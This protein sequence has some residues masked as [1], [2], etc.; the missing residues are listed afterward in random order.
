MKNIII[1]ICILISNFCFS[2]NKRQID[3][4][5]KLVQ[6]SNDTTK[7][8]CYN[9]LGKLYQ[10]NNNEKVKEYGLKIIELASK[11]KNQKY[12]AAGYLKIGVYFHLENKFDSALYYYNKTILLSKAYN[13]LII[14]ADAHQDLGILYSNMANDQKAID[15]LIIAQKIQHQLKNI[16]K[17]ADLLNNIAVIFIRQKN[18]N[19]AEKYILESI[20]L[21]D[22]TIQKGLLGYQYTNL[23]IIYE[24]RSQ[25]QKAINYQRKALLEFSQINDSRGMA[26]CY[27]NLF[28]SF[29]NQNKIDSALIFN[30]KL[31]IISKKQNDIGNEFFSNLNFA[32]VYQRFLNKPVYA[33]CY[34]DSMREF[35]PKLNKPEFYTVFYQESATYNLLYGNKD[36]GYFYMDK[37]LGLKDS[38]TSSENAQITNELQTKYETEKKDLE[39]K[40][41]NTEL[42]FQEEKNKQKTVVLWI[43]STALFCTLF[44][45]I[46]AFRNYKKAKKAN[47]II[48]DQNKI[49]ER[50]K[51]EVEIQKNIIEEKQSE[52]ISS[53]NYAQRIQS[54]VLTG[55]EVWNKI[56]KEHF[57]VFQPRDIVSGDFYWAH[58]LPNGRAVFALADCTGHGVPGGF[59]S[60]L[61]NSFLNEIIVEN[62]IFKADEILNRLR[63]KVIAALFQQG[64][65]EQKDGMDMALCVWNKMDNTIEFAGANNALYL[66]R[67]KQ[68]TEY[69]GDKMPIGTYLEENKKFSAQ[70]IS[71]IS[72]DMIYLS[73][74]GFADQFGGEKGKKFKYKQLEEL[75]LEV[76]EQQLQEQKNKLQRTFIDWKLNHEQ[77]D[78]VSVIGIRVG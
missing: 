28:L 53:I 47:K 73:T 3:S 74:D 26:A 16:N 63:D 24:N 46:I 67:D 49:L 57:I 18:N 7:L 44:F 25:F 77:T 10:S 64:Q 52:I 19:Q 60:M 58:V 32:I 76:S 20:A 5:L 68:L 62:K 51:Q 75:L 43:A 45:L 65:T 35:L 71:L 41:T 69:K 59:M 66:V 23:G 9:L 40:Q 2:Q 37:F 36:T 12:I 14:E 78:D 17:S 72:G 55:Q 6:N 42:N 34:L 48:N 8:N 56:S 50:Q 13:N 15:E 33:K 38:L 31:K 27:N 11:T 4:L 39:L 1:I 29:V 22:T 54:A 61:G 70:K 21:M 30:N